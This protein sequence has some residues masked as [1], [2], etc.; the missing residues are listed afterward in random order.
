MVQ[1]FDGGKTKCTQNFDKENFDEC[2]G[3]VFTNVK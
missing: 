3:H 2:E 1:K